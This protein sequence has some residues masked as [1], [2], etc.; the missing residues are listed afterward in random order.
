MSQ[1]KK[2]ARSGFTL[3][4]LLVVIAIIGV[5]MG[6]LLPAVQRIRAAANRTACENNIRQ[7]GLGL[8]AANSAQNRLPPAFGVYNGRFPPV[9]VGTTT[10]PY[11][12][13]LFYHLLPHLEQAGTYQRLAPLFLANNNYVLPPNAPVV[14]QGTPD[15]NAAQFKVPSYICPADT[16]GDS[17]GVTASSG[18]STANGSVWGEN[19]YAGNYLV[20][21][22]ISSPKIPESV[23]D[24]LSSTI[25]FTEK[26][27][28][29]GAGGNMW[30]AAP[31]W[32][33]SPQSNYGGTFGFNLFTMS[34][35]GFNIFTGPPS[36]SVIPVGN[37]SAIRT[38][39]PFQQITPG[40]GCN[41]LDAGSPHDSGINVAMGDGSSRFISNSVSQTTWQALVTPYPVLAL[42]Q[43]R[44]DVPGSD[45][46]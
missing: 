32:P 46:Q 6:L 30:A 45:W 28:I 25:F 24:G 37:N 18:L 20:F 5:L 10:V 12:A 11:G 8:Q 36:G 1:P 3:I 23:P 34:T 35:L 4:E 31:F 38:A 9:T 14:G 2:G 39:T 43:N 13:S 29:C 7:I 41:P 42:G 27:P 19:C 21:G 44:S 40:G 33:S 15:E 17:S 22:L 16:T 26:P